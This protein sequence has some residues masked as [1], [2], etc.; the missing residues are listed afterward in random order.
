M[1]LS[2]QHVRVLGDVTHLRRGQMPD[3]PEQ[4][5]SYQSGKFL[6]GLS[7]EAQRVVRVVRPDTTRRSSIRIPIASVRRRRTSSDGD[8][9]V[10][11]NSAAERPEIPP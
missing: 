11:A 2:S 6:P 4:R 5:E 7:V 9:T 10:A 3:V 1:T 8:R